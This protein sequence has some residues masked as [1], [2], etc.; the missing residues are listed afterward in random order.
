M[1]IY[2]AYPSYKPSGFEW[3]GNIPA[4]WDVCRLKFVCA[5]N[6]SKSEVSHLPDELE[7]SFLPME[8]VGN[9]TLD[10]ELKRSLKEIKQGFTYF[11]DGDVIVAKITPSFENGK[12]VLAFGLQNGIGFGTTELHVIRASKSI[13]R[14]FLY[15]LTLTHQFRGMGET[16]MF[17]T[18]GQKRVPDSFIN[19][20]PTPVPTLSEQYTIV[21]FLDYEIT[22][23]NTLIVKKRDLLDLLDKQRTAIISHA[24]TKGLNPDMPMKSSGV[25]W[26]G[27]VP[28]HWDVFRLKHIA[29][30]Q[31][32][33]V[34]KHTVEGQQEILLCNYTDV[35]NNE[36]ITSQIDFMK[37][38][39]TNEQIRRLSLYKN[40]V[41]L[42]KDSETPYDIGIPAI[43]TEDLP[44]VVCGYHLAVVSAKQSLAIGEF[45]FRAIQANSTKAYYFTEAPGITRYG[46]G[47]QAL[48]NTPI[49]LPPIVEQ[50]KIIE[51][52]S[53]ETLRI[54]NLKKNIHDGIELLEKQRIALI[55]AAVTG[56][57]DVREQ[58]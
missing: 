35:Y 24:V 39:A 6:P 48:S 52:I 16:Q 13:D 19:N 3:F 53:R 55:S 12:G 4:H 11:Q 33:N 34:D 10:L 15:Y 42:T 23:I 22:H 41:I 43:V 31:L 46:L 40:D 14:Q 25:E 57:I 5:V 17:G 49:A 30:I 58:G 27:D 36:K 56:K 1:S 38:T 21:D 50:Q 29:V 9:G 18:A 32:S 37:A 54:D 26:L 8:R 44:G 45:I 7:V 28:K 2:S 47:K 20:F 51:H